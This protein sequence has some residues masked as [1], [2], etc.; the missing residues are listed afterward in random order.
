[1]YKYIDLECY[2]LREC[3]QRNIFCNIHLKR[4][5]YDYKIYKNM[6]DE[7]K[8]ESE[9]NKETVI[10]RMRFGLC[11]KGKNFDDYDHQWWIYHL[12]KNMTREDIDGL[13]RSPEW[14]MVYK[15]TTAGETVLQYYRK[16]VKNNE[17]ECRRARDCRSK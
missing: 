17:L 3:S 15:N 14:N 2:C 12:I 7:N 8:T 10:R 16:I 9:N 11:Y 4:Q 1:M 5:D 13:K 6:T